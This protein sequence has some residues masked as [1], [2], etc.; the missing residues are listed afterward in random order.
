M[1]ETERKTSATRINEVLN[2]F[3]TFNEDLII[4]KL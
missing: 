1:A 4:K 3:V 2:N